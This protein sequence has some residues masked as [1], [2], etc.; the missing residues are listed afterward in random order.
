[1]QLSK[2]PD[3]QYSNTYRNILLLLNIAINACS[4]Q[5]KEHH[6]VDSFAEFW[7]PGGGTAVPITPVLPVPAQVKQCS[8]ATRS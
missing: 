5:H 6:A 3:L 1:M 7:V 2:M 4:G 8:P